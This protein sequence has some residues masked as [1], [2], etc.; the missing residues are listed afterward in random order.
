MTPV[1]INILSIAA[2]SAIAVIGVWI[3][4]A[5]LRRSNRERNR[6]DRDIAEET[7]DQNSFKI[8]TDQLFRLNDGLRLE[9]TELQGKVAA[10][11]MVVV[12]KEAHIKTLEDEAD[13]TNRA[14]RHQVDIARQLANYIRRLIKF[15]PSDAGPP[16]APEPPFDW[17]RHLD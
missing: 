2:P 10:L 17:E 8:V 13:E 11:E 15:W 3:T 4:A 7:N 16:P 9:M 12:Q 1:L 6:N 14:L 5:Y